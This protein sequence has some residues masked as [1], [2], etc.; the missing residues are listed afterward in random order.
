[1]GF[2][3]KVDASALSEVRVR[4]Q[5]PPHVEV[6]RLELYVNGRVQP[7]VVTA[8]G[9]MATDGGALSAQLPEPAAS[10]P[11]ALRLD[12]PVSGVDVDTDQVW[13]VV[14]RGGSGLNPTGGG[15]TYCY[16]A[17]LY[18]DQGDDGWVG[19]LEDTQTIVD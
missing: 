12:A 10:T 13:V 19:W 4:V 2:E 1:M 7:L 5:A 16:S 6:R 17:P 9:V 8:D 15:G 18:V 11:P 3:D 14:A